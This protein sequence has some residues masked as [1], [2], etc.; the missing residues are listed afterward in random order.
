MNWLKLASYL[1]VISALAGA[2][3]GSHIASQAPVAMAQSTDAGV[4]G[5]GEADWGASFTFVEQRTDGF[6]VYQLN[7]GG[8]LY[9]RFDDDQST[10]YVEYQLGTA[11]S[12][13]DMETFVINELLPGDAA[14]AG[15]YQ[16]I[17]VGSNFERRVTVHLYVSDVLVQLLPRYSGVILVAYAQDG[18]N[19]SLSIG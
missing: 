6:L 3:P 12:F 2:S 17:M 1:V 19:F 15:Q 9:V 16:D 13:S 18:F 5:Y 7:D 4:F 14:I 8:G 11:L 10:T